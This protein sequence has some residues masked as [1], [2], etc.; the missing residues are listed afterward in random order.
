MGKISRTILNSRLNT[1][2]NRVSGLKPLTPD[3]IKELEAALDLFNQT[4]EFTGN[5]CGNFLKLFENNF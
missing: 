4:G 5:E 3:E 1:L 2:E